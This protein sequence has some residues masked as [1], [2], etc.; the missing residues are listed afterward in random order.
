[1]K[2]SQYLVTIFLDALGKMGTM[3]KNKRR[4]LALPAR[5]PGYLE[6]IRRLQAQK[7]AIVMYHGVTDCPP[8][9]FNWCHLK[10]DEFARQIDFLVEHYTI[11]HLEEV[12]ERLH[13]GQSLP[14]RTAC[15]TFDDGFRSVA[16][17]AFPI[18]L[19]RQIPSTVFL[20]T[21]QVGTR[22]PAWPDRLY[23]NVACSTQGSVRFNGVEYHLG[24]NDDRATVYRRLAEQLKNMDLA[25]R[26]DRLARLTEALGNFRV[27]SEAVVATLDWSEV[28]ALARTGLVRFGSHTHTHPILSRCPVEVQREE[29][30]TSRNV[31]Q[32]RGLSASLF[33]Y[34]N[35][36]PADFT[37]DTQRLL[38]ELGYRCGL[39]TIPGLNRPYADLYTLRRVNV[40]ADILGLQFR[41]WMAGL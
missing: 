35:G 2:I 21:S 25:E 38:R 32:E 28:D 37:A 39:T 40:G 14:P 22:Q 8:A 11:L 3:P 7:I 29:L 36:R 27:P 30:E 16:T 23:W 4:L 31:L 24:S 12:I 1:M 18:L 6:L 10:V 5:V 9:V 33:A 19:R 34:P 13:R 17:T 20:V 41:L 15:V 26:E